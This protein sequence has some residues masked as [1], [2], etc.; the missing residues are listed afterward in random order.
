VKY[1]FPAQYFS[2]IASNWYSNCAL[3]HCTGSVSAL[4]SSQFRRE[5]LKR[6]SSVI[7]VGM[8]DAEAKYSIALCTDDDVSSSDAGSSRNEEVDRDSNSDRSDSGKGSSLDSSRSLSE[9]M[10]RDRGEG[11]EERHT[12]LEQ[13]QSQKQQKQQKQKQQKQQLHEELHEELFAILKPTSYLL[14]PLLKR[15]A[16]M[17][18]REKEV[19][20]PSLTLFSMAIQL[21]GRAFVIPFTLLWLAHLLLTRE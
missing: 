6:T 17:S 1:S 16:E 11:K 20:H 10:E 8:A 4:T 18:D 19:R 3:S 2:A 13:Q 5:N 14:P 7:A 9:V 21:L 12:N 15:S